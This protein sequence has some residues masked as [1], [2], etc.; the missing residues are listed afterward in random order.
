MAG[1]TLRF[2][3]LWIVVV[4]LLFAPRYYSMQKTLPISS[5][6]ELCAREKTAFYVSWPPLGGCLPKICAAHCPRDM[7]DPGLLLSCGAEVA[8]GISCAGSRGVSLL[9]ASPT[10]PATV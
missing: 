6:E 1:L 9:I 8:P 7:I 5:L 3:A 4:D 10:A 2:S